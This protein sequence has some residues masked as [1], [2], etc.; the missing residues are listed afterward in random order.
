MQNMMG[1]MRMMQRMG[2]M[3]EACTEMMQAMSNHPHQGM[4]EQKG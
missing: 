4:P 3:I 2:L 1:L